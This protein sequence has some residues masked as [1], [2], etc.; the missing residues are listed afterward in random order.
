MYSW[1]NERVCVYL[2]NLWWAANFEIISVH[3]T[4]FPWSRTSRFCYFSD[5]VL[6]HTPSRF[7]S[8]KFQACRPRRGLWSP[9]LC[10]QVQDT[11]SFRTR[12]PR[13][14]FSLYRRKVYYVFE[15]SRLLG[16]ASISRNPGMPTIPRGALTKN[17]QKLVSGPYRKNHLAQEGCELFRLNM[18]IMKWG[19]KRHSFPIQT[20]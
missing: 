19:C 15:I 14:S 7:G 13:A 9:N 12:S 16:P 17:Q 11:D 20:Y 4:A 10:L 2:C 3:A 6:Q 1:P 8:E 18:W 5:V